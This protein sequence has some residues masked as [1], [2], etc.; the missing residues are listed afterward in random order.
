MTV[1]GT[2]NLRRRVTAGEALADFP[3]SLP[4]S[5]ARCSFPGKAAN[6][7]PTRVPLSDDVLSKHVLFLGEIGSG[8][9]NAILHLISQLRR[10]MTSDDVMLIFDTKGDFYSEFYRTG[11]I[12]VSNDDKATGPEG[13]NYWNIFREVAL[14]AALEENILEIARSLFR[15]RSERSSQPF[16]P[17]AAKDLF[18]GIILHYC[19]TDPRRANNAMLRSF[20]DQAPASEIRTL[21]EQHDD[22]KAMVSYIADDRSPQTQGVISELQQMVREIFVGAFRQAGTL[23]MREAV[24]S[25]GGRLIFIE[26]DLG[27]GNVLAPIYRVL[28][29]LAIKQALC[30]TKSEGNVWFIID[31]FRLVP[32]LQHVDDGVNFGRGLGAKFVIGVQNVE[33]VFCAYGQALARS[34]LSGFLTTVAFRVND[35]ATRSF[36]Q[37]LYG[38]NR[39]YEAVASMQ[40]GKGLMEQVGEANVVEDWDVLRLEVGQCIVSL[41]GHGPFL[42]SFDRYG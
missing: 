30:R 5:P 4:V 19:R 42:F 9:T 40:S 39:V 14:D 13:P 29:D 8:K 27:M 34:I 20:L 32:N 3:P 24:Q 22:L 7:Q 26:Y 33:Q 25:K 2:G 6:G 16:F 35:P 15:E 38:K 21:L 11:D 31:E 12:V 36:V 41:P 10:S 28:V 23:S 17:N 37:Q 18:A 1:Q